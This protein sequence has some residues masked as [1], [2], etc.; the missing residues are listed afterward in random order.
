MYS[1]V[2]YQ[3]GLVYSGCRLVPRLSFRLW[4]SVPLWSNL[5]PRSPPPPSPPKKATS[6]EWINAHG[7]L[8]LG[9]LWSELPT[10]VLLVVPIGA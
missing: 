4:Y 5:Y 6:G 9:P 3:S 2:L 8:N 7:H 10:W 1:R